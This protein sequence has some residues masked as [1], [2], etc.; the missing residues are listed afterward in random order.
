M[1]SAANQHETEDVVNVVVC[2]FNSCSYLIHQSINSSIYYFVLSINIF[3]E[4]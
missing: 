2:F 3:Y 4:I 1:V